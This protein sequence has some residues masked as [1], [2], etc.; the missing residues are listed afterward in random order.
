MNVVMHVESR[1]SKHPCS[2]GKKPMKVE[3][4]K[5]ELRII[6][7]RDQKS[8]KHCSL[9]CRKVTVMP[10]VIVENFVRHREYC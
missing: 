9:A 8:R 10:Q 5:S 7:S 1:N 2:T 3:Q 4:E 6:I